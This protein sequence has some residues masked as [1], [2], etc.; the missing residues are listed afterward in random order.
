LLSAGDLAL[1]QIN[2]PL[3]A[4]Q[5]QTRD[6]PSPISLLSDVCQQHI[7]I[8]ASLWQVTSF[9]AVCPPSVRPSAVTVAKVDNHT[10]ACVFFFAVQRYCF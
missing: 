8:N 3:T 4:A 9:I 5:V 6:R 2:G 7:L 1:D 10:F